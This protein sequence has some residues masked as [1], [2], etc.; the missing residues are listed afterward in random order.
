[1]SRRAAADLQDELEIMQPVPKSRV[2]E[3]QEEMVQTAMR[4]KDEGLLTL[5]LGGDDDELV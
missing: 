5:P 4:L 1:M 3:S 2:E